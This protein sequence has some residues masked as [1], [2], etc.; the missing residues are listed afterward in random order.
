MDLCSTE[1]TYH[2]IL[3]RVR[4]TIVALQKGEVLNYVLW[5]CVCILS[6][7]A[8]KSHFSAPHLRWYL[9]RVWF[10]YIFP[11]YLINGKIFGK[12]FRNMNRV[13]WFPQQSLYEKFVVL[14]R[15]Q[16]DTIINVHTSL[17][18]VPKLI[19]DFNETWIFLTD[20]RK[21][22]KCEILRK[23]FQWEL[24]CFKRTEDQTWRSKSQ[25]ITFLAIA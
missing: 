12:A 13:L 20:F 6:F 9:C 1:C 14:R 25:L 18:K 16:G 11:H 8:C 3:R 10:Y 7:P 2:V 24:S 15:I 19:L 17:C 5:I 4:F 23:Y 22:V 21:I